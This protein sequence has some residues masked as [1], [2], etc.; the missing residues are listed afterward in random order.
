MNEL[1][2]GRL[3]AMS[4]FIHCCCAHNFSYIAHLSTFYSFSSLSFFSF[5]LLTLFFTSSSWLWT[6]QCENFVQFSAYKLGNDTEIGH[7]FKF[8]LSHERNRQILQK[9]CFILSVIRAF[10]LYGVTSNS[11]FLFLFLSFK[12]SRLR[13]DTLLMSLSV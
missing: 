5:L 3:L 13:F 8:S 2:F 9:I 6:F 11:C 10:S 1:H 12:I 7:A 4:V